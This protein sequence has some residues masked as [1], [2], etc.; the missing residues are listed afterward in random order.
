MALKHTQGHRMNEMPHRYRDR[1]K[2]LD[3]WSLYTLSLSLSL[4][5]LSIVTCTHA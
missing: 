2:D 3:R 5:P 4:S 1:F